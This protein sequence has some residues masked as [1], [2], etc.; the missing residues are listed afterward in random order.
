MLS[1]PRTGGWQFWIDR[2]GTFTDI[3]AHR[4]DGQIVTHKLLSENPERYR[5]A[6]VFGMRSLMGVSNDEP[7]PA[8]QVESIRMGTTVATNALLERKGEPTVLI[9]TDGFGDALRI[10][11][12]ARPD[13]FALDIVLPELLYTRVIEAA[14]RVSADGTVLQPLE[15]TALCTALA[16]AKNAGYKAA[17]VVLMHGYRYPAHEARIGELAAEAGFEQISLSH[18]VAPLIKLVSRGQTTV[19]DAYL[20]PV[21]S[22]YVNNVAREVKGDLDGEGADGP[23]LLFMQS[24]GGLTDASNFR[25]RDALLS[26]PAGGVVG[27]V[28]TATAAGIDRVVGFDMGGTS[29]DVSHYDGTYERT[30]ETT[31]AG[32]RVRVPMLEVHTVA[33]G[34]GSILHFDG[35]RLR[36]GPDSSG[37][38][39]GPR[40]YGRGGPLSVTD[41]NVLLG[42]LK[43]DFFPAVFGPNGDQP[44]DV[45]AVRL[46]FEELANEVNASS[47]VAKTPEE[48]AEDYLEIAVDEMANAVRA[49]S[50]QRGHDLENYALSCFGGAGGQHACLVADNLGITRIHLHPHAGVLSAYGIG[51][52]AVRS[53]AEHPVGEPLGNGVLGNLEQTLV[54]LGEQV[55]A[56]VAVSGS[57]A[58]ATITVVRRFSLRYEGS[59]VQLTVEGRD[60]AELT[61]AFRQRHQARFGFVSDERMLLVESVQVEAIGSPAEMPS[62]VGTQDL[63]L[64]T[65]RM[66]PVFMAGESCDA[67]FVDRYDLAAGES[68][69]GPAVIVERTGT[70]VIEPGWTAQAQTNGDL[71]LVRS[72]PKARKGK[73]YARDGESDAIP[74]D[75]TK[76]EIFNNLFMNIANQMGSVLANTAVSVNIKER[77]DFSCAIFSPDG[78]LVANAPHMPVH[79]GSM[80]E[81]VRAVAASETRLKPGDSV[82]TNNPY[83]GGTHLPDMTVVKPVFAEHTTSGHPEL[84]FYVASRGHH[85]DIGGKVPGS[86][87]AFSAHIDEEGVVFDNFLLVDGGRFSGERLR[88]LLGGGTYPARN[89]DHNVADL[90]AQLASCEKG[91]AEL[92]SAIDDYGLD[93]VHAY[94]GYVRANAEESVRRA[95]GRLRDG[96][97]EVTG[98][99]G[100]K[101][102]VTIT[103]DAAAGTAVVDF[104]GTSATHPTNFN[105]PR[106]VTVAAVLYVFRCLV[107]DD[108]PLNEGCLR[109]LRL[110]IPESCMINP[111]YPAA[112]VAGNVEVSQ[113]VVDALFG[114][115]GVA[116]ASQG[117]MNNVFWGND[118]H[119]YYETVC[120]GAGAT[121]RRDGCDAVH[122]H[123]T[124]SRLTDPEVLERR[125]PVLLESFR[126]QPNTGGAGANRGGDGVVRRVRFGEAMELNVLSNHRTTQP[127]GVAGGS[128]GSSGRNTIIRAD[129]TI[130]EF[131]AT[132]STDLRPGDVFVMQ[133]PGGGGY[134]A[135]TPGNPP[136]NQP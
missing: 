62:A 134:G 53:I 33:A 117:T 51:L 124:N 126:V 26:G 60:A 40:A 22:R 101:V 32:V 43:P 71:I 79:L 103:V 112:V 93:V 7:F 28:R 65:R 81:S 68:I 9:T 8:T 59:D 66:L 110:I 135:P 75:P 10:G 89:P 52:A 88:E 84:L 57:T 95:I 45:A 13:L 24:N 76:L 107:E 96:S 14:E 21:L 100:A 54:D 67:T 72:E 109:P 63:V 18:E 6:A 48:I 131:P 27:M 85:A 49:I 46:A 104:T 58:D 118:T 41:C 128:P 12:Q 82:L 77:L 61:E 127:Y 16:D 83:N 39:P 15:E 114:A 25:G 70:T 19:V 97:F 94:M 29:T 130:E 34:G 78:D 108:I 132:F 136:V 86:A 5:D 74:V 129:Q 2:G 73:S 87:P 120:G 113:M 36:V 111:T 20:S 121:S 23:Q 11:Y 119:Q 35:Q 1:N 98:D 115:L 80:A 50:V 55:R 69:A 56:A 122:T 92:L 90:Q 3:V 99:D 133:T 37:A 102:K 125:F 64:S 116:A 44:L 31:I 38:D 30:D 106:A 105:A 47:Q 91:A 17:A 4:P 123:M 42:K